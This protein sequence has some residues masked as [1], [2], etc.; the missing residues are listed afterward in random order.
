[1]VAGFVG[2]PPMN[3]LDATMTRMSNGEIAA[4]VGE[5]A[6]LSPESGSLK[7]MEGRDVVI[8]FR[9]EDTSFN[10]TPG[11]SL[12]NLTAEVYTVEPMGTFTIVTLK[13]VTLIKALLPLD[14][15][16]SV[17]DKGTIEVRKDRIRVFDK[18]SGK[19]IV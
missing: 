8:G 18:T 6:F 16:L 14:T 7:E 12:H 15:K 17:G 1:M 11:S 10:P 3:F 4:K 2:S 19:R 9:P 5:D 13:S